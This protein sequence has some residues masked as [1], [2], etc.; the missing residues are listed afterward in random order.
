MKCRIDP[1]TVLLLSPKLGGQVNN[2]RPKDSQHLTKEQARHVYKKTES[3]GKINTD[4]LQQEIEQ[5]IQLNRIDYTSR[6]SNP[7]KELIVNN[8]EKIE[9]LL[10]QMEQWSILSNTL[11]HIQYDRHPKNYHSLGISAANKCRR[12]ACINEEESDMLEL[13]F[14]QTPDILKEKNI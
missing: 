13:D 10:T 2:N 3:S 1:T 11:N 14:G 12:N 8:A 9:P 7:Y 4:T 6:D 5:E